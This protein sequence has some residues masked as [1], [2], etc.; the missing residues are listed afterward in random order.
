MAAESPHHGDAEPPRAPGFG[1]MF[2]RDRLTLGVFFA[3]ESYAGDTPTMERQLELTSTAEAAG[4]AAVWVRDVPLRDPTFGDVG[5]IYDPWVWLGLVTGATESIAL[6]T[7]AIVLPLRHPLDVAKAA[8]SVDDL[9]D[10]RLVLGVASGDRPV[11]FPAYGVD[12]SRRGE[13]FAEA[14]AYMREAL[15]RSFPVIDSPLGRLRGADLVPKPRYG[16]IPIAVTG[17]SR[18]TLEWIAANSDAWI[19]YPR[20]PEV[21]AQVVQAWR[22][23]VHRETKADW[24]PFAQSLYIDLQED[25]DAA[26]EPIHLGF[27]L[28]RHALTE[29]LEY[30]ERIG[31]NHVIFNLKYGRRPA[32]EVVDELGREVVPR[33]VA[34]GAQTPAAASR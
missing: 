27:R 6:A 15:E 26:P 32:A 17:S 18:Q 25:P 23:A 31:V 19:T 21:Q 4:F 10:G 22:A 14:L 33:F 12:Y 34:H 29:L 30:H 20:S 3:I 13:R 7:G 28:G 11:E 2:A 8:A 16:R 5:Q 9:S 24:K 1:R